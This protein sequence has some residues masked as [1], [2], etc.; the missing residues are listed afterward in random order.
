MVTRISVSKEVGE[1]VP[2]SIKP[3]GHNI[4]GEGKS[5]TTLFKF[6]FP[7]NKLTT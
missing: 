4:E 3:T 2:F 7:G 6:Y 1:V 5:C